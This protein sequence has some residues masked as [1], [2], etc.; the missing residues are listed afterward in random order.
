MFGDANSGMY[1][2]VA[3]A[4]YGA[5][6]G[7]MFGDSGWFVLLIILA[8]FGGF[9]N[10]FGNNGGGSQLYPWMNQAQMT[11]NGLN[12][13]QL[14]A[15]ISALQASVSNGSAQAEIGASNRQMSMMQQMFGLQNQ[16]NEC[17][18]E[19]RLATERLGNTILQ[20]G[21]S[22][23]QVLS[24]GFRDL[25]ASQLA[26]FQ[27]VLDTMCNYQIQ[28]KDE[29]IADL[30]R[31]LGEANSARLME[32]LGNRIVANNEAQTTTL[33]QYLAPKANPAWIVQ[34]PNC[35]GNQSPYGC[36]CSYN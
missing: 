8:A 28:A 10:G 22:T 11:Q 15:A 30:Q 4:Q 6:G 14:S 24:D 26:G 25:Q 12:D 23:R 31:Q 13:V 19:N 1:M 21:G 7:G 3:P 20:D 35:C 9:G 18:C 32:N 36:G 34:N 33:E 5:G 2:P 16:F 17:C 27:R 29:K